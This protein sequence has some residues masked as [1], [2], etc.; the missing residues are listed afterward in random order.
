GDTT[1]YSVTLNNTGSQKV[2]R[3]V[4]RVKTSQELR[5][6]KAIAPDGSPGQ[7]QGDTIIFNTMNDLLPNSTYNYQLEIEGVSVG[8]GR[9]FIELESDLTGKEPVRDVEQLSVIK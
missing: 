3:I 9:I 7:I 8:D 5:I 1:S 6:L 2:G 4:L